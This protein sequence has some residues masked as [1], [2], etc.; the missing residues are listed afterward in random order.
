MATFE[1]VFA[2]VRGTTTDPAGKRAD[3]AE[4]LRY[5]ID[6]LY[7]ARN[8]R[9]DLFIGKMT[10][11]FSTLIK[12]DTVP[13]ENQ[14]LRPIIDYVIG[15]AQMKDDAAILAARAELSAKLAVGYLM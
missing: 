2:S 12:T 5:A 4:L 13:I 7:F 3:D 10:T 11:D 14:F 9:P 6:A 15:R 1:N 8:I